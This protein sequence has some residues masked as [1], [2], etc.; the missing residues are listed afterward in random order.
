MAKV[1][2][3][4]LA[5]LVFSGIS[6]AQSLRIEWGQNY[7]TYQL[8]GHRLAG[9]EH[10]SNEDFTQDADFS[11]DILALDLD[12]VL[13]DPTQPGYFAFFCKGKSSC[14]SYTTTCQYKNPDFPRN[15]PGV[16]TADQTNGFVYCNEAYLQGCVSFLQNVR[17]AAKPVRS[18]PLESAASNPQP[19]QGQTTSS[20]VRQPTAQAQAP[21]ASNLHGLLASIG[22]L[23]GTNSGDSALDQLLR[24]IKPTQTPP[25]RS[26]QSV[27][28]TYAA[29]AQ[30]GGF[31][32]NGAWGVGTGTDLNSAIGAAGNTCRQGATICDDEGYCVLRPGLWGAWASDLQVAGNNAFTCN[33]TSEDAA[34]AQAQAWCGSGCKVLW[35]RAGL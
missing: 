24:N 13:S 18:A 12:N 35:S 19:P 29:F 25:K 28:F 3:L 23:S 4:W 2:A 27:H 22:W 31:D 8:V 10:F 21:G 34:R 20:P 11:A 33:L 7:A 16:F 15:C 14:L 26:T 32:A 5:L 17:T 9:H 30:A 6:A 1:I